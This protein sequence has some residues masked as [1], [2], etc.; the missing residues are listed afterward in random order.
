MGEQAA[1]CA[2]SRQTSCLLRHGSGPGTPAKRASARTC[3]PVEK[4]ICIFLCPSNLSVALP[5]S[6]P[7]SPN[8]PLPSMPDTSSPNREPAHIAKKEALQMQ[9]EALQMQFRTVRNEHENLKERIT[10]SLD[11]LATMH[12]Q[13]NSLQSH[14]QP[15]Q[16][17]QPT[18]TAEEASEQVADQAS[19]QD[20]DEQPCAQDALR[21]ADAPETEKT[22]A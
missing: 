22:Q 9:F 10:A 21:P 6:E 2:R 1:L 3:R 17:A 5:M 7:R 19:G 15:A 20:S 14:V 18:Q 16:A 11:D 4:C 12:Q 13:L 8:S